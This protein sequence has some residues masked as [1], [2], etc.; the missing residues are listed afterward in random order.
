MR[1]RAGRPR[2]E[3]KR[4]LWPASR[5]D[6][7]RRA[8]DWRSAGGPHYHEMWEGWRVGSQAPARTKRQAAESVRP[9]LGADQD[10]LRLAG[11]PPLDRGADS[12][13]L[14]L[15][16]LVA[17]VEVIDAQYLGLAFRDQASEDQTHRCAEVGRHDA[18]TRQPIDTVDDCRAPVDVDVGA[19]SAKFG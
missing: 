12:G 10:P 6:A 18:G 9:S 13:Q 2:R 15:Q 1:G 14:L 7:N 16:P 11:A 17:A 8:P 3:A 4:S 19:H 5:D